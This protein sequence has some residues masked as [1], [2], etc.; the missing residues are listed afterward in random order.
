MDLIHFYH[1]YH[2]QKTDN[3]TQINKTAARVQR[4]LKKETD[5]SFDHVTNGKTHMHTHTHKHTIIQYI[6][7]IIYTCMYMSHITHIL[8][9]SARTSLM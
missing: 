3:Y 1:L 4:T 5:Q 7:P 2:K 9:L 6:Y 8:Q